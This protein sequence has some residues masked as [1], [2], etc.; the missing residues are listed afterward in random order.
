MDRI[1]FFKEGYREQT[2]LWRT[3]YMKGKNSSREFIEKENAEY[4]AN[5][6]PTL[7]WQNK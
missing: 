3:I 6:D 1:K 7:K 2:G 5:P 4:I